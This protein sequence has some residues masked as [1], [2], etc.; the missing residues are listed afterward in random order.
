MFIELNLDKVK[1]FEILFMLCL[2]NNG[3]NFCISIFVLIFRY[4]Y[5]L[6]Y[7]FS[8]NMMCNC[9]SFIVFGWSWVFFKLCLIFDF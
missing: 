3:I 5:D 4:V 2:I 9:E 8:F 1:F 7:K 6:C